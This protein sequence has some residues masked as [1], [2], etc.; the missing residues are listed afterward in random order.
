MARTVT[1]ATLLA[2]VRALY[3]IRSISLDDALLCRWIN[4]SIAYLFDIIVSV[5]PDYF[6]SSDTIAV[7]S[8]TDTYSL[9]TQIADFYRGHGADVLLESGTYWPLR[10]YSHEERL[11]FAR[12][13]VSRGDQLYR[14]MGSNL[15][16]SPVPSWSG[17]IRVWYVPTA[18]VLHAGDVP[19][20][21]TTASTQATGA[22]G[23][24][25]AR[26]NLAAATVPVNGQLQ[27]FATEADRV[28]H[29]AT[30]YTG[31][32][33]TTLTAGKSAIVSIVAASSSAVAGEGTVTLVNVK[34]GTATTG[35]QVAPTAA[36]IQ[37]KVGAGLPWTEV[38]RVTFNR[39]SSPDT[40]ITQT[41][42]ATPNYI[43]L[44]NGW[45]EF[46]VFDT[47]LKCAIKEEASTTAIDAKRKELLEAIKAFAP[48]RDLS[49][50]DHIRDV[51][52]QWRSMMD[53]FRRLPWPG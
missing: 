25:A 44:M 39:A 9:P 6:L 21:P 53:P 20:A 43:D 45:D 11:L 33:A 10:Q 50:C 13:T 23:A 37:A 48:Q 34:G 29:S 46:C 52:Q 30:V 24:T 3:E 27:A 47:A 2:D 18:P 16:L 12:T 32:D 51:S 15:V 22:T 17:T 42:V 49:H 19:S 5:A 26:V 31:E 14:Y 38:A 1:I 41:Q 7:V 4:Q 40:T 8:G 36:I 28:L 35:S